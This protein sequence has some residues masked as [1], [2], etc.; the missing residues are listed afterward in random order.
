MANT[1]ANSFIMFIKHFIRSLV[2]QTSNK[3]KLVINY[4][5]IVE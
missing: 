5:L 1:N 3:L 4:F 2:R